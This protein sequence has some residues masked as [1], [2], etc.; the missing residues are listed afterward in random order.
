VRSKKIAIPNGVRL[1]CIAWD[2]E[3]GWIACGGDG[4]LLKVW[5]RLRLAGAAMSPGHHDG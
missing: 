2:R 3:Q 5:A 1:R 4:G